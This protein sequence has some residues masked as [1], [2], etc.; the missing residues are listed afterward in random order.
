MSADGV[1]AGVD[2]DRLGGGEDVTVD[3]TLWLE[4]WG[5][6]ERL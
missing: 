6:Y 5:H 3:R 4:I 1:I 2:E